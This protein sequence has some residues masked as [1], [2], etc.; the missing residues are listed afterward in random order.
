MDNLWGHNGSHFGNNN[1][2]HCI[3]LIAVF[4]LFFRVINLFHI[5]LLNPDFPVFPGNPVRIKVCSSK[6]HN[7]SEAYQLPGNQKKL[8]NWAIAWEADAAQYYLLKLFRKFS[9]AF[10]LLTASMPFCERIYVMS[11]FDFMISSSLSKNFR[12]RCLSSSG[13]PHSEVSMK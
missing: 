12:I 10:F 6:P 7:K 5:R 8:K 13:N 1:N 2:N 4:M 9:M 3:F 11:S